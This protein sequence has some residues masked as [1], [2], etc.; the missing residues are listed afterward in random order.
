[1]PRDVGHDEAKH[2]CRV[3]RHRR[4]KQLVRVFRLFDH[5]FERVDDR[6]QAWFRRFV[7]SARVAPAEAEKEK[8]NCKN[9]DERAAS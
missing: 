3:N 5:S 8:Q 6:F 1:M 7:E 9:I 2:R 4:N